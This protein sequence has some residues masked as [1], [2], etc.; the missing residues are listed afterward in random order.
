VKKNLKA[1]IRKKSPPKSHRYNIVFGLVILA[2]ILIPTFTPNL[3]AFDTNAPK[4]LAMAIVNLLAFITLF[5]NEQ[6]RQQ[7][8]SLGFFFKTGVGLV[9]LGFLAA[10]LLSLVNAINILE[11]LLQL[12]KVFTVF[13]AVYILSVIL[14]RDLRY[15]KW[16][17]IVFTG[18]LIFDSISVFYYINE[19][20]QG[21][22]NTIADIKSIYGN[23]N[24]FA[25]AIYVKLPFALWLMVFNKGWLKWLGWIGLLAGITATFFMATRAFYLGLIVITV[26]FLAYIL[27]SYFRKKQIIQLRLSGY[28]LLALALAYLVFTGT[29]QVLYPKS[30]SN[31]LT[32]GVG[33]QLS[34]IGTSDASVSKRIE[35]WKW[36]WELFKEKPLFGVGSGNWK[37]VVLKYENKEEPEFTYANKAHNDF[38]ETAAE[39]GFIGG[40]LYLC[41]FALIAWAFLKQLFYGNYEQDDLFSYMFLAASGIA[42][43][44]VDAFFNFPA[45]RPEIQVLF[46]IYVAAG[47]SVIHHLKKRSGGEVSLQKPG[48]VKSTLIWSS[49]AVAI[50]VL[51]GVS[52]IASLNFKSSKTQ[53]IVFN[54][55]ESGKLKAASDKIIAG[56]PF[57]PNLTSL[58]EPINSQKARYLLDEGKNEE[59]IAIL[60]ADRSSPWDGRCEFHLAK[61][62]YNLKQLDSVLVYTEK[63]REIKP[64]LFINVRMACEILEKKKEIEKASSYLETYL[65][66]NKNNDQAWVYAAGFYNRI[67]D[68]DKA[69]ALIEEAKKYLPKDTLVE[70]QHK[71][72]YQLKFV[73]PYRVQYNMAVEQ[74]NKKNYTSALECINQFILD[75]PGDFDAHRLRAFIYYYQNNYH[76][77][78][79]EIDYALTL[80][81]GNGEIINLRGV[82]Y[83][84]LKEP[85]AACKDFNTAM[86]MGIKEG[87]TNY[88]RFCN[89]IPQ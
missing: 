12:T 43:Y 3:M 51:S 83:Y 30:I 19:F 50:I 9:Y 21:R 32:L 26:V 65:A 61:G 73:D 81:A 70:K 82:C 29:Q 34:T 41:I 45:D 57:I 11:S 59:A 68:V 15:L 64:N 62:F 55:I 53:R 78:I 76:K 48:N 8:G 22:L 6:I 66:S 88:E 86:Q 72:V 79:E 44:S 23:K 42:F 74:I 85:E 58:G 17:V 40:L 49:I 37:V 27:I 67:G 20:I 25:S 39:T 1:K 54:E 14:M 10:S 38:F 52:Y 5:T 18:L 84:A 46:S 69:W 75:V 71:I 47:I 13:S 4:F 24:G 2:Y 89:D 35:A 87:K 33:Q 56:F 7:P 36:T 28:Y 60:R 63:L 16:I 31:R 77:S 80:S